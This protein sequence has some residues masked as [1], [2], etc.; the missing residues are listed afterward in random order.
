MAVCATCGAEAPAAARFCPSCGASL[1]GARETRKT[2]TIL[3]CDW[4]DSTE[5]GEAFDPES[6][7]LV[8]GAYYAEA[9]AVLER[10]GGM[11]E[12]F[13]GDAVMAVFGIPRAREDDALRAVR[14]AVE[15][16]EAIAR[17]NERLERDHGLRLATRT[18]VNTGEVVAGDPSAGQAFVTGDAVVVAKRLEEAAPPGE[19]LV[20]SATRR[21]VRDA[22]VVEPVDELPLKG[23]TQP[24]S[25]WRLLGVLAGAPAFVRRL[26]SE[27]VG[28]TLELEVL[29]KAFAR[30]SADGTG[31][32]FTILGTAGV[33]KSR[34][35]QELLDNLGS[36]AT[37]LRGQCL[38][39]G[40]GI[41]FWPLGDVVRM[42]AGIDRTVAPDV[43]RG[44]IAELLAED[45]EAERIVDHVAAA[46]GLGDVAGST[47]E[48]FWAMRRLL[49]AL[50]RDRPVVVAFDDLHWAEPTF[51][52][53]L[54][55]LGDHARDAPIVL[56]CLARPDLLDARPTWAGG[57]VNASTIL[58]E[59]LSVGECDVLIG[60]LLGD[61]EVDAETRRA[62]VETAEG[63]PLFVEEILAML[64]DDGAIRPDVVWRVDGAASIR[65]P[66]TIQA[67]LEARLDRLEP[68]EQSV[69]EAAAVMGT[70]FRR[71]G[72]D[73]L[74]PELEV[75][76]PLGALVRKELIRPDRSL[77]GA[78]F[79]FRHVLIRDAAYGRVPKERRAELHESFSG[80][81][82]R[83]YAGRLREIE[84]IVAHHLEQA[85]RLRA[86]LGQQDERTRRLAAR[87]GALLAS[88]GSRALA[89]ED[90]P[91]AI[92]L[93]ERGAALLASDAEPLSSVLLDLATA[94]RERGDLVR[95]DAVLADAIEA[96]DA[97]GRPHLRSRALVERSSLAAYVDPGV[98][99]D[100]LLRVA[101]EAIDV[102][103]EGGDELGLA[104]AWL[105]V[106][107]VHWMRCRCGEMEDALERALLHA[108]RAGAKRERSSALGSLSRAALLGPR[109]VEKAIERCSWARS[110]SE[111]DVMVEAYADACTAVLEAMRG[112]HEEAVR[113]YERTKE[114]L[115][116]VGLSLLLA[117]IRMYAGLAELV[118]GDQ[119]AAERELRFGY[120]ALDRIGERA[121]LS[122]MAAF[123]A[124]AVYGLDRLDE[125][126]QLTQISEEAASK[127]DI[128]SQVTWRGT[129]AKVLAR[130]GDTRAAELAAEAVAL[131]RETDFVN[132][133][134]DALADL[135][136]TMRLLGR[137]DAELVA[138]GEALRLYE[139]KGNVVSAA[140]LRPL[141]AVGTA[142]RG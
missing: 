17:L 65:V 72:L 121:Y 134:A 61:V 102:F 29:R 83:E 112:R 138:L 90:I 66:P 12:K 87:A 133:Q 57:K 126:T 74:L 42:A 21:L 125:A 73:E 119:A 92:T 19:I 63:N 54:E 6:L 84:E 77:P 3:F 108:D 99:A 69:L 38:P 103:A 91:A 137:P 58:L 44:R 100:D 135:A 89:R 62:I 36:T 14:A 8:Q 111:G 78:A 105:H 27:L 127:D 11:L 51:L 1:V 113:L 25:A 95:A 13:I 16:R 116:D 132:V 76:P 48:T 114:T 96:A 139:A 33:G 39:Y 34:L 49:E 53:L 88:A 52:D 94:L 142:P 81:L 31:H 101:G 110:R 2:V 80:W 131:S 28:R 4:V 15:L 10:H 117:S 104:K 43:A 82:E 64:L 128:G 32:L 140:F 20:S 35:V 37:V 56:V 122:T 59:P 18:G 5:I 60:N 55:Y 50:A 115:Q 68:A 67:L 93:L 30:A 71:V 79:R 106:A 109:P 24:V 129:R 9:R 7:R 124:R 70:K 97:T 46:I 41:T 136:E 120:D 22:A 130:R 118:T 40:D 86:E 123:L 47:E 107:E 23:K 98:Q 26:D 45:P 141:L 75:E 85:H